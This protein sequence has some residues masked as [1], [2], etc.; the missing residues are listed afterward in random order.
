LHCDEEEKRDR[1][2]LLYIFLYEYVGYTKEAIIAAKH[3]LM[4]AKLALDNFHHDITKLMTRT[5][6]R[7]S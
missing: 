7:K 1:T 5:H 6:L 4:K 3:Q 2:L